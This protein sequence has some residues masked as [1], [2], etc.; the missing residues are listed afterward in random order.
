MV[1]LHHSEQERKAKRQ[2]VLI[3]SKLHST[4]AGPVDLIISN[5]AAKEVHLHRSIYGVTTIAQSLVQNQTHVFEVTLAESEKPSTIQFEGLWLSKGGALTSPCE[6]PVKQK[7][8]EPNTADG[9]TLSKNRDCGKRH[10]QLVEIVAPASIL[11]KLPQDKTSDKLAIH[12]LNTWSDL[13]RQRF[14]DLTTS[15]IP[16]S[17]SACLSRRC[18]IAQTADRSIQQ[19]LIS[20]LFFRAGQPETDLYRHL[21]Q[22]GSSLNSNASPTALI[23]VIG[24]VDM[25]EF[26]HSTSGKQHEITSFLDEFAR[27]YSAFIQTIRRTAYSSSSLA[28]YQNLDGS[29]SD[30]FID[31]SFLY[32]SAP[33][34]LSIFLVLQPLP[35]S[36]ISP[37]AEHI[38]TLLH[39]ATS[40]VIDDLKWHIGDKMTFVVDTAGW[41][42]DEDFMQDLPSDGNDSNLVKGSLTQIGHIK[43]AHHMSLH[44]CHYIVDRAIGGS[45]RPFDRHD[46]YVG[47]LYLPDADDI[48][49]ILEE[50]KIAPIKAMFGVS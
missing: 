40:K 49:K 35:S 15:Q 20:E 44:L 43:F 47:N 5:M 8:L 48:K 6:S 11:Q 42:T 34:T 3:P 23:L 24:T 32:N 25:I 29:R 28:S 14:N 17:S 45:E 26:L 1:S 22:F 37:S 2:L 19:P 18:Q 31:E 33:S 9:S 27:T 16:L 38:R 50:K 39:H 41:L 7:S 30:A 46:E 36:L 12:R 4:R 10:K 13:L 21:W